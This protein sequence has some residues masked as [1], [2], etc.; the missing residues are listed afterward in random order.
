MGRYLGPQCKLCRSEG[1]KLFLKGER[2]LTDKCAM[3][4][5]AY[6][7]GEHGKRRLKES[8]YRL[9]LREKQKTK[10]VYCLL[11]KQFKN[12]YELAARRKGITGENLLQ[13]LELRLDN[14]IYR[15]GFAFSRNEARQF[16]GHGFFAINGRRVD[17]PSY[18]VRPGEVI[19]LTEAGKKVA[20]IEENVKS[21]SKA[22]VP[23]W[24]EVDYNNYVGKVLTVP[25]RDQIDTPVREQLIVELYSK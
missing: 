7:P 5:R 12:Y 23:T 25:T 17:I 16:V 4:R 22:K 14:V 11:E 2:C 1:E 15:L 8:E 19:T 13:L 9:Q 20:R 24:L 10:R 18:R 6:L 3:E 21:S